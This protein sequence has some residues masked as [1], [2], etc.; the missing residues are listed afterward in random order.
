MER[1]K[2]S[3]RKIQKFNRMVEIDHILD[4]GD[5]DIREKEGELKG[6]Q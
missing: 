2:L 3:D 4:N 6:L 1:L 5:G